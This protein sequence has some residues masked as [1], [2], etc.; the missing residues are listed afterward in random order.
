MLISVEIVKVM[1]SMIDLKDEIRPRASFSVPEERTQE[2]RSEDS[3]WKSP[4]MFE[5]SADGGVIGQQLV[6]ITECLSI[7]HNVTSQL[8]NILTKL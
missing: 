4:A 8:M 6:H 2:C 5:I 1:L 3:I 7:R